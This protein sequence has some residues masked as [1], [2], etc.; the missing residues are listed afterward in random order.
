MTDI[1]IVSGF[2]GAGKTTLIQKL[3]RE[4]FGGKRIVLL[5]NDFGDVSVDAALMRS[6]G[7]T[8]REINS[9]CICCSL[10]GDFVEAA[11]EVIGQYK[12]D[13]VIVEPSGVGKLSDIQRLCEDPRLVTLARLNISVTVADGSRFRQYLDNFGEF[14]V[15]QLESADVVLL[16]RME[17]MPN[18]GLS[19]LEDIQDL[20]MHA[21][22]FLTPLDKLD[23]NAL[24]VKRETKPRGHEHHH[25]H[26]HDH[27]HHHDHDHDHDH[28]HDHEHCGENCCCGHNHN[29]AAGEVFDAFTLYSDRIYDKEELTRTIGAMRE[30]SGDGIIRL[31][32]MLRS[33]SGYWSVQY[34]P[35]EI[36]VDPCDVSGNMVSVIGVGLDQEKLRAVFAGEAG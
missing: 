9:G 12:P 27:D 16:N 32:G 3:L 4:A 21:R 17:D 28:H 13:A 26:D 36:H 14:F 1:Y 5:E 34:M 31:K 6:S 23:S 33:P 29:H 35:G 8:V 22:V 19:V 30:S 24:L 15:D 10:Q 11:R 2:L 7:A 25:D 20:H 18:R